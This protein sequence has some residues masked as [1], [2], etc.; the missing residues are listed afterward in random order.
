M[1]E[2]S[3]R[4]AGRY[5]RRGGFGR[6]GRPTRGLHK[7]YQAQYAGDQRLRNLGFVRNSMGRS[8]AGCGP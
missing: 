6:C 8:R 2:R 5:G 4:G 7:Q 1:G 3:E